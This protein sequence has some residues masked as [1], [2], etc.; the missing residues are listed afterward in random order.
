MEEIEK[1]ILFK[2]I[3]KTNNFNKIFSPTKPL[4]NIGMSKNNQNK[5]KEYNNTK[6][7]V[8]NHNN[9]LSEIS[10]SSKQIDQKFNLKYIITN[11]KFTQAKLRSNTETNYG[12]SV[13][14][15][16]RLSNNIHCIRKDKEKQLPVVLNKRNDV[17]KCLKEV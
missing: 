5:F 8:Y 6:N 1:N 3:S 17:F 9:N 14:N 2:K 10:P 7:S 16:K 11:H 4:L 12:N 13:E 15:I